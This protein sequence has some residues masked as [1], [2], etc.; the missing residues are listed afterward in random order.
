MIGIDDGTTLIRD[1]GHL[2]RDIL[3]YDSMILMGAEEVSRLCR[4]DITDVVSFEHVAD[5][6]DFLLSTPY[7]A[8]KPFRTPSIP[9][10]DASDDERS[11]LR[12]AV[13]AYENVTSAIAELER[14]QSEMRDKD[15]L[16]RL[17]ATQ[18][19]LVTRM[20]AVY[21]RAGGRLAV[22]NCP[23]PSAPS[24]G[25]QGLSVGNVLQLV[26]NRVS[27]P[28]ETTPWQ[29]ILDLKSDK[30]LVDRAR[31]LRIWAMKTA[32]SETSL[33]VAEEHVSDLISDYERYLHAHK[34]KFTSTA[35]QAV[36]VGAADLLEDIV[37]F[38]LGKLARRVFAA[39][40][41]Q[42]EMILSEA[43][44]PGR[45]LSLVTVLNERL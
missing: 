34:L 40:A 37:K 45:E 28:C 36:V 41:F 2:K 18:F 44:A 3:F 17:R 1:L 8:A 31:K 42:A 38:R 43:Q 20:E 35:I 6:I 29:D 30:D 5:E 27:I 12:D 22:S 32:S 9:L 33:Q 10:R 14:D 25:T 21:Q 15:E 39:R 4:L 26:I 13:L 11:A 24:N 19:S 23:I 16:R 7:F